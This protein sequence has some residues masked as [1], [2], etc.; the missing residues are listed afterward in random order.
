MTSPQ[1]LGTLVPDAD[2][3][4]PEDPIASRLSLAADP[5]D[6]TLSSIT[7]SHA[8]AL[9]RAAIAGGGVGEAL[10]GL[11]TREQ[12]QKDRSRSRRRKGTW[13]KLLWVRQSCMSSALSCDYPE[14]DVRY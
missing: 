14:W 3:L 10:P 11:R 7:A 13:K 1:P 2:R 12:R 5:P 6:A 4:A 8:Q 9:R